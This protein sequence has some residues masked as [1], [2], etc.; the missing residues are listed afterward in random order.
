MNDNNANKDELN[1]GNNNVLFIMAI[2]KQLLHKKLLCYFNKNF[3]L[4]YF[5]I[6]LILF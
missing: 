4:F 5:I 6:L 3:I 1:N 2:W